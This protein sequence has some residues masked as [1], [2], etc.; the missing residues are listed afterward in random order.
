MAA[1]GQDLA[2]VE[3]LVLQI[4]VREQWRRLAGRVAAPQAAGEQ[5][6]VEVGRGA[7]QH[8]DRGQRHQRVDDREG[9]HGDDDGPQLHEDAQ[10]AEEEEHAAPDRRHGRAD[11]GAPHVQ[12][13]QARARLAELPGREA[14][15]P[16]QGPA[17]FAA[18][19]AAALGVLLVALL[20]AVPLPG[21]QEEH[22]APHFGLY[23]L[24]V[25]L[26]HLAVVVRYVEGVGD[27]VADE[28]DEGYHLDGPNLPA[29]DGDHEEGQ[30]A[31]DAHDE[32][33]H[34]EGEDR[35]AREHQHA[36]PRG[37][38]GD[39]DRVRGGPDDGDL[40]LRPHPDPRRVPRAVPR[41]GRRAVPLAHEAVPLRHVVQGRGGRHVVGGVGVVG[42]LAGPHLP[43][44]HPQVLLPLD[45]ARRVP[46]DEVLVEAPGREPQAARPLPEVEVA[47]P[48]LQLHDAEVLGQVLAHRQHR[49]LG[50]G[51][52]RLE[53]GVEAPDHLRRPHERRGLRRADPEEDGD[54]DL[55][56]LRHEGLR[57]RPR[58]GRGGR[59]L[60]RGPLVPARRRHVVRPQGRPAGDVARLC[61][62]EAERADLA[63]DQWARREGARHVRVPVHDTAAGAGL[64]LRARVVAF[65][66]VLGD[67]GSPALETVGPEPP[68]LGQLEE[69]AHR[70]TACLPVLERQLLDLVGHQRGGDGGH[71]GG[72]GAHPHPGQ[73]L[74][75]RRRRRRQ[76]GLHGDVAAG[77]QVEA[78]AVAVVPLE[79]RRATHA[80]ARPWVRRR[81][82]RARLA[83]MEHAPHRPV[84]VRRSVGGGAH[85]ALPR[86]CGVQGGDR[87]ELK[88]QLCPGDLVVA[89]REDLRDAL[90]QLRACD[91]PDEEHHQAQDGDQQQGAGASRDP[92]RE[93]EERA[94]HA[95]LLLRL[96][97]RR[98]RRGERAPVPRRDVHDAVLL[99]LLRAALAEHDERREEEQDEH[100]GAHHAEAHEKP[101]LAE[102]LQAARQVREEAHRGRQRR[103]EAALPGVRKHPHNPQ[104]QLVELGAL[105]PEVHEH[106]DDV[107]AD[108]QDDE[109]G[110]EGRDGRLPRRR[111]DVRHGD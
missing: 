12:H 68:D 80:G 8:E 54:V 13:R 2:A 18:C 15:R 51:V 74:G 72:H 6:L 19:R 93:L 62:H 95:L 27:G 100:E 25:G 30:A 10:G 22:P 79:Q 69:A 83:P 1:S 97:R 29:H 64:A 21:A 66:G 44:H 111:Q 43:V 78:E 50:P 47:D 23:H 42:D 58:R 17:C 5:R 60:P 98:C 106:E 84:P 36:E 63:S 49:A 11:R 89:G 70:H 108:A 40:G 41:H 86:Q 52:L 87:G 35:V 16:L 101:E 73:L 67:S 105:V 81:R 38:A 32:A 76:A 82:R 96:V 28:D 59:Q 65:V 107:A 56:A 99:D 46:P 103:G 85:D 55:L 45:R 7:E 53:G 91:D 31:D 110:E 9:R 39:D 4:R 37:G 90:V 3:G 48:A 61:A 14:G 24:A 88:R 102:W 104:L 34:E 20:G 77:L 33:E 92:A 26:V 109:D 94:V 71:H 57:Q 75:V